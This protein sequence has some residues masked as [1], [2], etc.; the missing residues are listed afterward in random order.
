MFKKL[1][2]GVAAAAIL[3]V[4]ALASAHV[5]VT[6]AT[7]NVGDY[8]TFNISVPNEKSSDVTALRL[9]VPAG[10]G[11][12]TPTVKA[13]WTITTTKNGG[14][15]TS[16]SWAGGT[17]PVGLRDDFT[18]RAQAPAKA[19]ELDW[20]AYQTYAD[21]TVVH[22]DQKPAGS[23]DSTGDA[24]PYSVTKVSNDLT[25]AVAATS[26]SSGNTLALVVSL[27]ALVI[28]VGGVLFRK[29]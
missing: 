2:S 19:T 16:I 24:G 14:N 6:P 4:P 17:I 27:A 8:V 20:K 5:V 13:G 22:W 28:A 29:K 26:G 25:Q 15:I 9:D 7:A 10:L 12:V 18:F 3:L 1:I 23:D 21:G 11:E